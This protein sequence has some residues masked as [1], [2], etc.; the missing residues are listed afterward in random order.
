MVCKPHP[1]SYPL[2][3]GLARRLLR[4]SYRLSQWLVEILILTRND[5]FQPFLE[6]PEGYVTIRLMTPLCISLIMKSTLNNV[7]S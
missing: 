6:L 1:T 3:S 4:L 7:Y 5:R 2:H